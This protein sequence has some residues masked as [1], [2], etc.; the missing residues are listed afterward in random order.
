MENKKQ[1]WASLPVD[2]LAP[3]IVK[4]TE[5]YFEYLQTTGLMRKFMKSHNVFYGHSFSGMF[6]S[7]SEIAYGGEQGE[8]NL[9]KVNEYRLNI[10]HVLVM[11]TQTRPALDA[12]ATNT[13]SKSKE[14]T[15]L[16]NGILGYY[17][18]EKRLE[19]FLKTACEH[20]LIWGEGY[21]EMEWDTQTGAPYGVD[22]GT[23]KVLKE[24]D[25]RYRN[26]MGPMEV[27]RDV[28]S[29]EYNP[30]DWKIVIRH[31]NKFDL[32]AQYPEFEDEIHA[33]A[34]SLMDSKY[35]DIAGMNSSKSGVQIPV[36]FFYHPDS[37]ALPGGRYAICLDA[38]TILFDGPMPYEN[39]P[40][41]IPLY[42]IVPAELYGTA[43]GYT[44]AWDALGLCEV[45]DALHSTIVTNNTTF[46]VQNVLVP[47]G[48]D[49]G[50]Q[51]LTGG[52]NLI[53]YDPKLGK[54]EAL[55]LT[56]TAPETYKYADDN[57]RKISLLLGVNEVIKGDPQASLESG[58]ALALVANQALQFNSGLQASY[59][60]LLE[61][62]GTATI[63]MLQTFANTKR[64]ASIA[65]T[66]ERFMLREFSAQ[67]LDQVN[68]VVVDVANPLSQT[69]SG[70]LEM[71]K[72]LLQ[73]PGAIQSVDQ[74]IQVIE[75]G[76]L[77]PL[78]EDKENVLL[79]MDIEN[80]M[81]AG[82]QKPTPI[83]TDKHQLH[84]NSHTGVLAMPD[85]RQDTSVV[86]AVLSHIQDHINLLA[87]ADPRILIVTGQQP[88]PP[89]PPPGQPPQGPQQGPP[90]PQGPQGQPHVMH[91][92]V[93]QHPPGPPQG[94]GMGGPPQIT[95]P[96]PPIQQKAGGIRQAQMP[97]NPMTGQKFNPTPNPQG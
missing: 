6:Q 38:K 9:V 85:A 76:Q 67:D 34:V 2:E 65:G 1:Y 25:I 58:S 88:L 95:N 74:Y 75:T 20:A 49:I 12:R 14:Q 45:N 22:P 96:T 11:T 24:G 69:V 26:P 19:R 53:E 77:R 30:R 27:I 87:T 63:R 21:V 17:L 44:H 54:P 82:G 36:K 18:R 66:K 91:P 33:Q 4:R 89:P 81:L 28:Y 59:T 7:S 55:Q 97:K 79:T 47:R 50:Y 13:D 94:P 48:H 80:E 83:I 39:L 43:F 31:M 64:V 93:P 57:S 68:S 8:L 90:P 37:S 29:Q 42:R 72:D 32:I 51:Q 86:Q 92:P 41:G 78:T 61:D 15:I 62:V 73:V 3:E 10:N 40:N 70:R 71:A 52:L 23:G 46:G 60:A 35:S 5:E 84:I 16:A 56:K